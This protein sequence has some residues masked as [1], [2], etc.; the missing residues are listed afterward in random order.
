VHRVRVGIYD[1][2]PGSSEEIGF[3]SV[4]QSRKNWI[5][6]QVADIRG[7]ATTVEQAIIGA[8]RDLDTIPDAVIMSFPSRGFV[9][10]VITTQYIRADAT[11]PITMHEVDQMISRIEGES[12]V[13]ARTRSQRQ[14][15]IQSDDLR[16]I[17]ST[18]VAIMIDGRTVSSPIGF[19][20]SRLRLTVLNVFAPS[21]EFNMIRSIL[22]TLD[23]HAIS[24][25]PEPLILPKVVEDLGMPD[26]TTVII[27]VGQS[28]IT[29]T[30][31]DHGQIIGFEI[32]PY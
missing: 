29:V 11:V 12:S 22:S 8:S 27:D 10:D 16:L 28:H 1:I 26:S 9:S 30:L 15:G 5:D 4:R 18:I 13:R 17:S 6:G 32:F 21:S 3:S 19:M 23:K 31:M 14:F 2:L 7:I 25:I 24:I 20:G